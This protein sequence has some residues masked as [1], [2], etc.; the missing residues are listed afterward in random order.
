MDDAPP[1]AA[2]LSQPSTSEAATGDLGTCQN[3]PNVATIDYS[4]TALSQFILFASPSFDL[5]SNQSFC[6][7]LCPVLK[8]VARQ[9]NLT[10]TLPT[11]VHS[12]LRKAWRGSHNRD[13]M[14]SLSNHLGPRRSYG[15]YQVS[16]GSLL[17][18]MLS[19]P[20]A[21]TRFLV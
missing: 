16:E 15:Y 8:W 13:F 11:L 7:V 17:L 19:K 10:P 14:T 18:N 1:K 9:V 20:N 21:S 2:V 5:L 12:Y 4:F 3:L 6:L